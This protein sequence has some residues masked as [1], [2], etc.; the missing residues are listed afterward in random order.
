MS[1]TITTPS[2]TDRAVAVSA[3]VQNLVNAAEQDP[4][5]K[6]DLQ[7]AFDSYSHNP[8]IAGLASIAGIMLA[9]QHISVDSTVLTVVIGVIVTGLGY[10]W[11]W[12]SMK[13][14]GTH[15]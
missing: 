14:K 4:T 13:L 6:A 12:A 9:Q 2:P 3:T 8:V 1:T 7:T 10:G 15:A 11:Q 5:V